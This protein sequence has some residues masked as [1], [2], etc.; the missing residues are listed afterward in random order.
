VVA[1]IELRGFVEEETLRLLRL[2]LRG[3]I[4]VEASLVRKRWGV[5]EQTVGSRVMEAHLSS[6]ED[7]Q[8]LVL[9]DRTRVEALAPMPLDRL[10][11]RFSDRDGAGSRLAVRAGVWLQVVT[12]SSLSKVAAWATE[13]SEDEASSALTRGLLAAVV[14]DLTRSAECTC[15]V[16]PSSPR[17][18]RPKGRDP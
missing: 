6:A 2:G 16:L 14:D 12:V 10:A 1:E 18:T 8:A 17:E 11:L 4:R 13:S 3:R 9:N 15:A 5:F 7:G